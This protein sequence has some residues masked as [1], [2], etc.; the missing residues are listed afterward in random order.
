MSNNLDCLELSKQ[1]IRFKSVTPNSEGS[2]EFLS[3]LLQELGFKCELKTFTGNNSYPVQ[4]LYARYGTQS[5]VLGFCGHLDVVP[6]GKTENWQ[7]DPFIPTESLWP[8]EINNI[9]G[10]KA[11]N[12]KNNAEDKEL[13]LVGRGAE[14]MKTGVACFLSATA[15]FIKSK[16]FKGSI[17]FLITMDEEALS[18]N[19]IEPLMKW[20]N[21]QGEKIDDC[22]VGEPSSIY[23]LG[24]YIKIGRR[25][26]LDFDLKVKGKQGHIA[27]P[28]DFNNPLRTLIKVVDEFNSLV[29]D[30]GTSY[31]PASNLE[32]V[33][34]DTNNTAYNLVPAEAKAIGNIRFNNLHSFEQ[35][36]EQLNYIVSKYEGVAIAFENKPSNASI[37][38]INCRVYQCMS[39]AINNILK[40]S[41]QP[42]TKGGTSDARFIAN[43][44][45]VVEFGLP[46]RTLHQANERVKIKDLYT[47]TEVYK[48]FLSQYFIS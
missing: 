11:F 26:S 38:D 43:Y 15:D 40:I 4:N 6:A 44:C 9:E 31:F 29:L 3:T 18:V 27:Y 20:L 8:I 39:K 42:T 1:L 41:P 7:S 25:G 5:P 24:D 14:D 2:I 16:Q 10:V 17:V 36:K 37:I 33:S 23:T 28:K 12:T 32:V 30:Q 22:L 34:I 13:F 47:L 35:L 48:E 46:S 19:G 21:N 45:P